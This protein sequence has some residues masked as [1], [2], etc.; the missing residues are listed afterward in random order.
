MKKNNREIQKSSPFLASIIKLFFDLIK[1]FIKDFENMRKVKKIDHIAE[2]FSLLEHMLIRL[3]NKI[4]ENR[5]LIEDLKNR[6]LWGNI[7]IVVLL[8]I[9]LY[10]LLR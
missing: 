5:K 1:H 9:I 7:I 2:K 4:Q 8:L 6:I 10:D 3:E